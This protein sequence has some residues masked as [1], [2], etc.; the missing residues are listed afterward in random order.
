MELKDTSLPEHCSCCK[1]FGKSVFCQLATKSL[2]ELSLQKSF[3]S[4]QKDD[5]IINA[6]SIPK[7]VF[8]L[9]KGEI[10]VIRPDSFGKNRI[11]YTVPEGHLIGYRS[12]LNEKP[13]PHT[14]CSLTES[15]LCFIP[16]KAFMD[17]A[18]SDVLL[19]GRL[20]KMLSD[21]LKQA[22]NDIIRMARRPATE[23]L[24]EAILIRFY[25]CG[26]P[27]IGSWMGLPALTGASKELTLEILQ[28]FKDQQLI[29][30]NSKS[31]VLLNIEGLQHITENHLSG[32]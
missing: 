14:V 2:N 26:K 24:A 29:D 4:F 15:T 9:C 17:L 30:F 25:Q 22:E 7:G 19:S 27:E 3:L 13:Y 23:R 1:Q 31:I 8:C 12:I 11:A 16:R 18:E 32:F 28:Q 20:I 6:G 10:G 5:V 21:E